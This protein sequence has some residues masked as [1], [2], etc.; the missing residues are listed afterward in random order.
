RA[1]HSNEMT[2]NRWIGIALTLLAAGL[3]YGLFL[4]H[5]VAPAVV[6]Y[7][8]VPSE[9][10]LLGEV[11]Y[12][13]FIYNYTPGVLWLNAMLFKLLGTTLM[14]AR[15]GVY[16]AKL[17]AALLLYL[18]A[19]RYLPPWLAL[20]PVAMTLCWVGYG[21]IL[22]VF[23]TQYGMVFLLA[24]WVVLNKSDSSVRRGKIDE[25]LLVAA[26]GALAGGVLVFK[27]NVGVF[28]CGAVV[29]GAAA[30]AWSRRDLRENALVPP[31]ATPE[32]P[33]PLNPSKLSTHSRCFA[34]LAGIA[35]V[36]GSGA[37]YLSSN[38]ALGPMLDHFLR[39]AVA[40]EEAKGIALP[41]PSMLLASTV[42]A[43]AVAAI[44]L[45]MLKN[46]RRLIPGFLAL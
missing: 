29:L 42:A 21:D 41:R 16:A 36:V 31:A 45:V 10:V 25:V 40:Y 19:S 18:L 12:R 6:G 26:A 23:P 15:A 27:H 28:V 8:L 38:S 43:I 5:G 22:K 20:L 35:V 32:R 46:S 2:R 24:A 4:R 37:L 1:S 39:H 33:G 17:A 34:V 30:A 13:D 9:R 7:N 44:S 3:A 11:P 14:T